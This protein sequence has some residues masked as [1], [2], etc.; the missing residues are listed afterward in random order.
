MYFF[1]P[2]EEKGFNG[3]RIFF[4]L[5]TAITWAFVKQIKIDGRVSEILVSCLAVRVT[6]TIFIFFVGVTHHEANKNKNKPC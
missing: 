4:F 6:L 5:L 3:K 1:H 2:P